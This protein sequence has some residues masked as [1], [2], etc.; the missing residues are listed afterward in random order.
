VRTT[1]A[2]TFPLIPQKPLNR[3]PIAQIINRSSTAFQ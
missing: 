3:I 2:P 1:H